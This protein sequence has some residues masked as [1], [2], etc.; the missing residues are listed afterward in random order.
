VT[1]H[2]VALVVAAI[3]AVS[4]GSATLAA[5]QGQSS[6]P[7]AVAASGEAATLWL[8][9]PFGKIPGGT[10]SQ[11]APA[12]GERILDT[13]V[14]DAPIAL[15]VWPTELSVDSWE[16]V[17]G[18]GPA[19]TVLASGG[20]FDARETLVGFMGPS[21]SGDHLLIART[22]MANGDEIVAAWRVSV[23]ERPFPADGVMDIPAPDL[24][25]TV[26][27]H[28]VIGERADGCYLYLCVTIGRLPPDSR[29][30]TLVATDGDRLRLTLTDSTDFQIR[31][32][33][34]VRLDGDADA[35]AL[36][37][38]QTSGTEVEV[39]APP[40]GAWLLSVEVVFDRGRGLVETVFRLLPDDPAA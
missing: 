7:D 28:S 22:V 4:S 15:G 31:D 1:P 34:Y 23:P 40:S 5:A 39:P 36:E 9:G 27:D 24:T 35:I 8:D 11:P 32:A 26:G 30:P 29:L 2:R 19:A 12:P 38:M 10:L 3:I 21:S 13:W 16:V 17:L 20:R 37:P 25:L 6:S 18:D 33:E 14:M